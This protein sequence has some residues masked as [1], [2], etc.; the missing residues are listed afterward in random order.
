MRAY[1]ATSGIALWENKSFNGPAMLHHN[2][3]LMAGKACDLM[4]GAPRLREHP[5]SGEPVEW[6]WSR[7][8]GCNTP[9]ASEHLLRLRSGAAGYRDRCTD[10]GTGN[11]GGFRSSCS[12]SLM[13]A[14]GLLTAPDYTRTCVCS[15]QNQTSIAL[16][17]MPEV[18]TWTF[19]GS[20]MPKGPVRRL[21][22]NLAAPGDRKADD[23]TL[24]L[25]YPSVGG[26]SP[27]VEVSIEPKEPEWFRRHSSQ[28]TGPGLSWV[29]ASGAKGL[30]T[31][32]IKLADK[33]A[34]AR[35]YSV[36]LH[37]MEPDDLKVGDRVFDIRLQGQA[38]IQ[39]LDVAREAGGRNLSI[40]K[41]VRGVEV[42]DDL[43]VEL[44]PSPSAKVQASL[45][46][47]IEIQAE[48]W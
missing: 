19:F 4:T 9:M 18:E 34:A 27:A 20:Q 48:G 35:K 6:T 5:L 25:E 7:N 11:F 2:T 16:V 17:P 26:S 23:G 46:S 28:V 32:R 43:L 39:I 30:T 47:G 38:A 13:V 14:G 40:V 10:G 33:G 36:K 21:G 29:A 31:I 24:W 1:Q 8:Y 45:L 44:T 3:V 41:T 37:F 42:S 12:N 15:Y 22:I